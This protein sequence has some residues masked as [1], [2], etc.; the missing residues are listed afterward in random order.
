MVA[1]I[2]FD[3]IIRMNDVGYRKKEPQWFAIQEKITLDTIM[4]ASD[5]ALGKHLKYMFQKL[6]IEIEKYKNQK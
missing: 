4:Y 5:A 6:Q 2:R 1:A 3:A